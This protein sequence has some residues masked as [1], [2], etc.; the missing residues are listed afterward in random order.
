MESWKLEDD[1]EDEELE[2]VAAVEVG[3]EDAAAAPAALEATIVAL[4]VF[5]EEDD[6]LITEL[7]FELDELET[8]PGLETWST[9]CVPSAM[10]PEG[11][12]GHDPAG[13]SAEV[14]PNGI[15]PASPTARLPTKVVSEAPWN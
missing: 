1:D 13:L 7:E 5:A 14:I 15:V 4:E 9:N 12:A 8:V 3:V 10:G 6:A 11:F 2:E